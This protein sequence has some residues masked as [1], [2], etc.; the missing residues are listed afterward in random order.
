MMQPAP[1]PTSTSDLWSPG[2]PAWKAAYWALTAA[3]FVTAVISTQRIRAGFLSNYAADLTCP[4]WL[5]IS[6]RGLQGSRPKALARY[7]AATPEQAALVLF[8]GS[9]LTELAQIWWPR[10]FFAGTFDPYDVLAYAIGVGTC[11]VA[12]RISMAR[13]GARK[14]QP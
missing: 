4:A 14:L 13:A 9:T 6:L 3:F 12:E 5:Y 1:T 11:Y 8:G 7:V 2:S 10:G